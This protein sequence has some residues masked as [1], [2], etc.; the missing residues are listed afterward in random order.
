VLLPRS[1]TRNHVLRLLFKLCLTVLRVI[2]FC[3]YKNDEQRAA[4]RIIIVCVYVYGTTVVPSGRLSSVR[5]VSKF[6]HIVPWYLLV[7]SAA[8]GLS[9]DGIV[10]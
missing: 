9:S 7:V 1:A 5:D 10:L 2:N 6:S 8:D 4:V 3:V